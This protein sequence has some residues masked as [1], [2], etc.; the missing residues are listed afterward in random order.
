MALLY[1]A[2][3]GCCINVSLVSS[4][5]LITVQM[6]AP[7]SRHALFCQ[8]DRMDARHANLPRIAKS[9]WPIKN[10]A[11]SAMPEYGAGGGAPHEQFAARRLKRETPKTYERSLLHTIV[12][13]PA[14]AHSTHTECVVSPDL[15][16][17]L[18]VAVQYSLTQHSTLS[19][20]LAPAAHDRRRAAY[21]T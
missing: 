7:A 6:A 11:Q 10:Y 17:E 18:S 1:G 4:D 9:I 20:T 5:F 2:G 16:P 21:T 14:I 19:T 3:W 15:F 8:A 13:T 12:Y